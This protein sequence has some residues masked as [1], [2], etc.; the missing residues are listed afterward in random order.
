VFLP[1]V[2]AVWIVWRP[3]G[4]GPIA[5]KGADHDQMASAAA[6]RRV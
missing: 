6:A 3:L 1:P 4:R 5:N 2:L